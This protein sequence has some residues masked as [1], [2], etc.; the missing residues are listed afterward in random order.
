M[1]VISPRMASEFADVVYDVLT[2]HAGSGRTPVRA[3]KELEKHFHLEQGNGPIKGETGGFLG[4]F[5]TQTGFAILGQGQKKYQGHH[6]IAVRGSRTTPDWLTNANFG[7]ATSYNNSSVHI[8]FNDTFSSM[9]PALEKR[10][11]R[12][13][14]EA[15]TKTVHCVG[16]SLGGA[17]ASLIADW[18]KAEFGCKVNLY[19]FGAPRVG[20]SGYAR[21][22]TFNIDRHF[23]CTH[24]ADP[25]PLVPL[26]P[27]QHAPTEGLGEYRLDGA[28]GISTAAHKMDETGSPGYRNTA[29]TDDWRALKTRSVHLLDQ[30]V[31]LR[32]EDRFR[33]SFTGYWADRL[34]AALTTLLKDSGYYSAMALQAGF[35]TTFTF[36]DRLAKCLEKVADASTQFAEQTAGLLGHMLVFAGKAAVKVTELTFRFIRWVFDKTMGALYRCAEQALNRL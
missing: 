8:G 3:S 34:S 17:L 12:Q 4:F 14:R 6:V 23:R 7:V 15:R 27:F 9:R 13:I 36:Y 24:G 35:G 30:P 20:L 16:H 11:G 10:L 32:Y 28:D 1:E 29:N 22:S 33:A 26:W 19:T 25:I 2:P 18:V 21:K 5:E 31:R